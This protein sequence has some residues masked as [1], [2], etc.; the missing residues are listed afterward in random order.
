MTDPPAPSSRALLSCALIVV[1]A[2]VLVVGLLVLDSE[3]RASLALVV[4]PAAALIAAAAAI[5]R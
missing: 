3:A 1:G 5:A 4:G 2:V